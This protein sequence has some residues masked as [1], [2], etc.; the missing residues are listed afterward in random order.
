MILDI[1]WMICINMDTVVGSLVFLKITLQNYPLTVDRLGTLHGH[2]GCSADDPNPGSCGHSH[3]EV[4]QW[5][6]DAS[7][8]LCCRGWNMNKHW[9]W[10]CS[11]M[12][13]IIIILLLK[14]VFSINL[15]HSV[16]LDVE[17]V[18]FLF[19]ASG[20]GTRCV[21]VCNQHGTW[22]GIPL[23]LVLYIGN[24]LPEINLSGS[25]SYKW[26]KPLRRGLKLE[27]TM[28]MS[29]KQQP[30]ALLLTC[31]KLYIR[32]VDGSEIPNS[33]PTCMFHPF[34]PCKQYS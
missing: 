21:Q 34:S 3:G 20:V 25:N 19:F 5:R 10:G 17:L 18:I 8:G 29:S 6:W 9:G 24:L 27:T 12:R 31:Y 11:I 1:L 15:Y 26:L 2:V 23:Y 7:A 30:L 22:S 28:V 4:E 33:H 16:F 32:T 14:H 13:M